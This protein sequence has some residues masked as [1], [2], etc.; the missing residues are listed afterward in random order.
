MLQP[1]FFKRAISATP[2]DLAD[3]IIQ[4]L[5]WNEKSLLIE[6]LFANLNQ[7]GHGLVFRI[8]QQA[9][10]ASSCEHRATANVHLPMSNPTMTTTPHFSLT[11]IDT[12]S[13]PD[14]WQAF[15]R[16]HCRRWFHVCN[17]DIGYRRWDQNATQCIRPCM[18][19]NEL[20]S[21][22]YCC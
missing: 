9:Q 2:V 13:S 7:F 21:P 4:R 5:A 16:K 14:R 6:I 11:L 10:F 15:S 3:Q 19:I 17:H 1:V 22:G 12:M 20:V 18:K 8:L